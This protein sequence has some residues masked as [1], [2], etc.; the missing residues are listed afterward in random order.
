MPTAPEQRRAL[1]GLT[2]LAKRE[3]FDLWATLDGL[4]AAET[5]DALA[6]LLPDIGDRYGAAAAALA[7]DWYDDLARR[8]VEYQ[9]KPTGPHAFPSA[10]DRD[11]LDKR[12]KGAE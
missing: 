8:G 12:M 3:L 4:G 5:R 2:A 7:A 11:E 6:A 9:P 10:A 1:I